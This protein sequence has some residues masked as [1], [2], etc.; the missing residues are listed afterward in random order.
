MHHIVA[1]NFTELSEE[2]LLFILQRRNHP[3]VRRWMAHPE[4]IAAQDHLAYCA[5]LKERPETLLLYVTYD[6]APACVLSYKAHDASWQEIDDSG[7]YGFDPAP[8]STAIVSQLMR[9]KLAALKGIKQVRIKVLST[10]EMALFACQYYHGYRITGSD[11]KYAHLELSL[12]EP[13]SV[14]QAQ[15]EAQL[16]KL[17]ATLELKL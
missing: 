8:C 11:D 2:Q 16:T 10:N 15:L 7:C 9:L 4:P 12:P 14:Y 6:G 17:H 13:R 3:E 1:T 5:T